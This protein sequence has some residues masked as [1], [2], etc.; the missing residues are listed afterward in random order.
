M[1]I[2]Q[3]RIYL[4]PLNHI[5]TSESN[6]SRLLPAIS[7]HRPL[8]FNIYIYKATNRQLFHKVLFA[9]C[10]INHRQS[11]WWS[12]H[13]WY[14]GLYSRS[15]ICTPTFHVPSSDEV[16]WIIH[17]KWCQWECRWSCISTSTQ[18]ENDFGHLSFSLYKNYVPRF[19]AHFSP[20]YIQPPPFHICSMNCVIVGNTISQM[21]IMYAVL[22]GVEMV[23]WMGFSLD[24]SAFMR[25][26]SLSSLWYCDHHWR[27]KREMSSNFDS[28][29]ARPWKNI[30]FR[31]IL[32]GWILLSN[33]I[34]NN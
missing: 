23:H 16:K 15:K 13:R 33:Y 19:R 5:K 26:I 8:N 7:I 28:L 24:G 27:D 31:E 3:G 4:N 22:A 17:S 6:R 2:S 29:V 25:T 32:V 30:Y 20:R 14:D 11:T 9:S 12:C 1:I 21:R 10:E 34:I 18:C